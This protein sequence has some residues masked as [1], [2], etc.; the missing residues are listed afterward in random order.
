MENNN[1]EN[2][3]GWRGKLLYP[4]RA[5]GCSKQSCKKPASKGESTGGQ[6]K[7]N[8]KQ[9]IDILSKLK[10]ISILVI[11]DYFLDKYLKIDP[12]KSELSI[13]TNLEAYQIVHKKSNP[14]AAGTVTNN[15]TSLGVG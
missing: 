5:Q 7:V 15:L 13:E 12:G 2:C 9:L 6:Q 14:G 1:G 10:D 11:G 3:C 4:G 8:E